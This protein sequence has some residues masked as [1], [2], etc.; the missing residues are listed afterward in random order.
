MLTSPRRTRFNISQDSSIGFLTDGDAD[1]A[2]NLANTSAVNAP[3]WLW[4]P[5]FRLCILRAL[6]QPAQPDHRKGGGMPFLRRSKLAVHIL[7]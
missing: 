2:S 6:H 4:K 3:V 1:F 7:H 5:G